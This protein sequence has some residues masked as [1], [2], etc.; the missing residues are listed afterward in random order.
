MRQRR[1]GVY[2]PYPHRRKWRVDT[3][4]ETGKRRCRLFEAEREALDYIKAAERALGLETGITGEKALEEYELYLK[5]QGNKAKS[6]ESTVYKIGRLLGNSAGKMLRLISVH[7]AQELY[8]KIAAE[9][10]VDSHR[11]MLAETK[12]W[13]TWCV[14]QRHIKASPWAAVDGVG[15]R[16][17]GKEQLRND[18]GRRLYVACLRK[19]SRGAIA[20][21][22]AMT[23]G[24]R[25]SE[26]LSRA[27]RD[28]DD[29]GATLLIPRGK[30]KSARRKLEVAPELQD[31]L[32]RLAAG[33]GPFEL[34]FG[35]HGAHGTSWLRKWAHAMCT[36]AKVPY[37][38]PHGLRGTFSSVQIRTIGLAELTQ[39]AMGHGSAKVT[40]GGNYAEEEAVAE[41][42]QKRRL[43]LLQGGRK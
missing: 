12:T 19:A 17:K 43:E 23:M 1:A 26:I 25:A 21:A 41:M 7:E 37:V 42:N 16:S 28:L 4:A 2:G 5:V 11:N 15:A 40:L 9:L 29:G 10:A 36:A 18:E 8:D 31:H 39:V 27:A 24:M 6:I 13:A 30:T 35:D 33:K 14:K 22:M 32:R 38:C 20:I 34:L 3:I